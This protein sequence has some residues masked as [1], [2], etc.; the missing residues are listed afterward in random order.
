MTASFAAAA[1]SGL[2]F[3]VGLGGVELCANVRGFGGGLLLEVVGP[4]LGLVRFGGGERL[5]GKV[6]SASARVFSTS[7][8]RSDAVEGLRL[9]L[10][11]RGGFLGLVGR[12]GSLGRLAGER[13]GLAPRGR[14]GI[15]VRHE[16]RGMGELDR[17][18]LFR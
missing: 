7:S 18:G 6:S 10:R 8:F 5:V 15:P 9:A 14:D 17:L 16:Q 2:D 1:A 3:R 12:L 11:C 4:R 13:L